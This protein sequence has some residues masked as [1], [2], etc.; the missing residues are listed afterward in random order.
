M[1]IQIKSMQQK[2]NKASNLVAIVTPLIITATLPVIIM[3]KIHNLDVNPMS[4]GHWDEL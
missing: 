3:S 2:N 1:H 4:R